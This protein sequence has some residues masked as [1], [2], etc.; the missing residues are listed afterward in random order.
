MVRDVLGIDVKRVFILLA[1]TAAVLFAAISLMPGE[2]AAQTAS[3]NGKIVYAGYDTELQQQDIYTINPDGTGMTNLTKNYSI[4]SWSPLGGTKDTPEWSPDGTKIVFD[5]SALDYQGSCC[6]RSVY[7]MDADG[8]NLQRLTNTPSS[9]QGEDYDATWASDGS[10]LAFTST[11]SEG[12]HDPDN[13]SSNASDDRE[14]YRMNADGTNEQQLTDTPSVSSD[15]QPS[16][17]PDG[18]KIAFASSQ[19]YERFGDPDGDQLDIYVMDANGGPAERLTFESGTRD[20]TLS[21]LSESRNPAWSPDGTRI[22]YESTRS[23][24]SEIWVM[25]VDG[26]GEPVSVSNDPAWDSEPAWSPDGTQI[27]FTRGHGDSG[28]IWAV[29]APPPASLTTAASFSVLKV[30]TDTA[31]AASAPRNLTANTDMV[32]NSP[33]WGTASSGGAISCTIKGTSG[34]DNLTGTS[35]ADVICGLGGPDSI[36]GRGGAD[37][38]RGGSG[39]DT[40]E[41]GSGADELYGGDG[42]DS[43]DA[44]DGVRGNDAS[45]G[46]PGADSCKGDRGDEKTDCP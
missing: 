45:S 30:G 20:P 4:P 12:P 21:M 23:G 46:G 16:I 31:L 1:A 34:V 28:D 43:L 3:S 27:T 39:T 13:P 18:T 8:T 26:T 19:H 2:P 33:D 36:E 37:V 35:G 7:V 11:R 14:I 41:G 5:A 32:A 29:D 40:I 10:W 22:A 44:A 25:N 15:E 24:N 9:F 17:S 38:L 42:A 6:S